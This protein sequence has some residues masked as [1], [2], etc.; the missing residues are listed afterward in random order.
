MGH[1]IVPVRRKEVIVSI[2][3]EV[4]TELEEF[5]TYLTENPGEA[6]LVTFTNDD[7]EPDVEALDVWRRQ[8]KSYLE[9]REAGALAFRKLRTDSLPAHSIR[10]TINTPGTPVEAEPAEANGKAGK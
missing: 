3:D 2:P 5:Y 6:G 8:A 4:K 1:T 10:F 7:G 9:T